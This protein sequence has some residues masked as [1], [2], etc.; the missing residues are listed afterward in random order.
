MTRRSPD[1]INGLLS[2]GLIRI[3]ASFATFDSALPSARTNPAHLVKARQCHIPQV[4][5]HYRRGVTG[6]QRSKRRNPSAA[7]AASLR[8]AAARSSSHRKSIVTYC[9]SRCYKHSKSESSTEDKV[10]QDCSTE[11][12]R[13]TIAGVKW[14]LAPGKGAAWSTAVQRFA[15]EL[16]GLSLFSKP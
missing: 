9:A 12:S 6:N 13:P 7:S 4:Y 14:R 5:R 3:Q 8:S 16:L 10:L 11:R 15:R 2:G 1:V